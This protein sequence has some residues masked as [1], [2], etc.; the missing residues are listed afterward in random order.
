MA[1]DGGHPIVRWSRKKEAFNITEPGKKRIQNR[2]RNRLRVKTLV[3][4][5]AEGGYS[6]MD[7]HGSKGRLIAIVGLPGSGKTKFIAQHYNKGV[8]II[9]DIG[10][11]RT[12]NCQDA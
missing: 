1:G 12:W 7:E 3:P 6:Q 9:D 5:A 10:D 4:P 8:L 2:V 11:N